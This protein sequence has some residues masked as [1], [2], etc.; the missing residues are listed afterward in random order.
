[1]RS[2]LIILILAVFSLTAS[3]SNA[4]ETKPIKRPK[5]TGVAHIALYVKD[6]ESSRKFYKDFLGYAEPFKLMSTDGSKLALTYIKINDRQVLELFPEKVANSNRLYHFAVE[7]D[8]AEGMRLYL[9]SK[10]CKVPATTPV[11]RTGNLNYFV[12]DPNGTICEI[13]QFGKDGYNTKN[14][15]KDLPA[16]RI[17]QRMSHVGFMVPDLDLATSFY[18]DILGFKET[19][20]GSKD[21]KNVS[22]VNLK[23]PEGNDYIELMLYNK[24]PSRSN[25]GSMNHL[26]LE[27]SDITT[28]LNTLKQRTLP[29]SCKMASEP[30]TGINKKRQIN[31]F[32]ADGTR[33][34]I[35]E[36]NTIDGKPVPSSPMPP[37]KFVKNAITAKI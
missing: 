5:I 26:C 1:M 24:E 2:K 4:Q 10:G 17:S 19:W 34:E 33:V 13:V 14:M 27:V 22:W 11:G 9:A 8:D 3:L 29:D 35:M 28:A 12:T 30:K 7:T 21:D 20:R 31:C 23:V 36:A 16:T 15:G 18:C 32:D 37:L 6:I 25:M